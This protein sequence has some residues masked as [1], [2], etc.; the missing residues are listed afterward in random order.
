M[1]KEN[2][3]PNKK[4]M[5][6]TIMLWFLCTWMLLIDT[7]Y[8]FGVTITFLMTLG[9]LTSHLSLLYGTK[10]NRVDIG[11]EVAE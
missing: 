3:E 1:K 11:F 9:F 7:S 10:E 6:L 8:E 5:L 4:L 2:T